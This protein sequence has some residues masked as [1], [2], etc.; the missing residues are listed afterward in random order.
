MMGM[1]TIK[2]PQNI[3]R[4]YEIDA[5]EM[6]EELIAQLMRVQHQRE[7][8]AEDVLLGL[9]A[10][11]A[12]LLDVITESAMQARERDLLRSYDG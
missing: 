9:F 8:G 3:Q 12:E 1:I 6:I 4:E 7:P 2:V 11:D 5:S 10:D